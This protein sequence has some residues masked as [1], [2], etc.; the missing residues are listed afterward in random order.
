[1]VG[2]EGHGKR[3]GLL[4]LNLAGVWRF[5]GLEELHY[6]MML[7]LSSSPEGCLAIHVFRI[8]ANVLLL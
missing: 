7:I 1:M 2:F 5:A 3:F 8:G 4:G 6:P